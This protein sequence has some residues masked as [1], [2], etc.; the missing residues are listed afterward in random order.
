MYFDMQ[1]MVSNDGGVIIPMFANYVF[2]NSDRIGKPEQLASNWD[3]DGQRW[4]ERW[5]FV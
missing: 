1:E 4:I 5:W 2:A 3:V